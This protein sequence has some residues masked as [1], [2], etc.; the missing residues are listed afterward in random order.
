MKYKIFSIDVFDSF[1]PD[2]IINTFKFAPPVLLGSHILP[3]GSSKV[4][5]LLSH[6]TKVAINGG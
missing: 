3:N 5:Q 6:L 4:F 2:I 1:I